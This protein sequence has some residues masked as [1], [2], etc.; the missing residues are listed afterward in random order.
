ME[1]CVARMSQLDEED[2]ATSRIG[3]YVQRWVRPG[4]GGVGVVRTGLTP[5]VF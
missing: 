1:R 5:F 4:L 3:T 2:P